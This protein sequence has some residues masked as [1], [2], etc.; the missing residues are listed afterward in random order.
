MKSYS[1]AQKRY[2]SFCQAYQLPP[3]PLS[4]LSVCLFAAFLAHE[5]LKSQSISVY[6]SALRHLQVSA[7]LPAPDRAEW[8]RLQY[9][10]K[11]IARS[12][13]AAPSKCLPITASM[14]RQLQIASA[15]IFSGSVESKLFW[16]ACCL[17]FFGFMRSGEFTSPSRVL[18]SQPA[19]TLGDVAVD[20]HANPKLIKVTLRRAKTDPFGRGVDIFFGRTSATVCP[21]AAILDYLAIRPKGEG[22]LLVHA[23][24]SPLTRDQ[25]VRA[26]KRAL[27]AANIDS[28]LYSGHSFRIGAATAAAAAGVPAYF[29]KMLGRWESEAYAIYI[30]TPREALASIS[31]L[32]AE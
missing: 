17:G 20:S 22:P 9:V 10:L 27:Q 25:F 29:I 12:Q 8:P 28:S 31:T 15:E 24:G 3:L 19:I 4:E 18:T 26:V 16:A 6:L 5:G 30:K 2:M 11:G 23:D 32:I 7:G 14:M 1:S 13:V 21:V